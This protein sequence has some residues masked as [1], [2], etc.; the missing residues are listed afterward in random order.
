MAPGSLGSP[1]VL[2][3]TLGDEEDSSKSNALRKP[4]ASTHSVAGA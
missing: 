4:P 3:G 1:E 2:P